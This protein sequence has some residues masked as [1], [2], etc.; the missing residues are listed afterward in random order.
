[1]DACYNYASL[2][3]RRSSLGAHEA[4]RLLSHFQV[5]KLTHMFK[6]WFDAYSMDTISQDN[7]DDWLEKLR[8]HCDYSKDD[9]RHQRNLD[10]FS[11]LFESLKDQA[12]AEKGT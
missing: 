11:V 7:I 2:G 10:V 12:K 9:T 4:N 3:G 8:K 5:A 1:M 6:V